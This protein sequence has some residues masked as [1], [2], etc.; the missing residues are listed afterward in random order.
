MFQVGNGR[1]LAAAVSA[2]ACALQ[3][4]GHTS[5]QPT[6]RF[7]VNG[8]APRV[9]LSRLPRLPACSGAC[10]STWV[11]G[12]ATCRRARAS[13]STLMARSTTASGRQGSG[14]G[15]SAASD[16]ETVHVHAVRGWCCPA[17]HAW[18]Q[19][20]GLPAANCLFDWAVLGCR[21]GRGKFAF[22]R[23]RYDGTWLEDRQHGAGACQTEAGDKYVGE[24]MGSRQLA[25]LRSTAGWWCALR[26][27]GM[28]PQAPNCLSALLCIA[29]LQASLPRG[30]GRGGGAACM[31]TAASMRVRGQPCCLLPAAVCRHRC[32]ALRQRGNVGHLTCVRPAMLH[33]IR[34]LPNTLPPACCRR[35]AE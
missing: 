23:Y 8:R 21:N 26:V 2:Q 24:W 9:C 29:C 6:P 17:W 35:V 12:R 10:A 4:S 34:A 20:C 22:N 16:P 31:Q 32:Q 7:C 18:R 33:T 1:A 28:L 30:G 19:A 3:P 25:W 11:S 5:R 27:G 13:A 15:C 14:G